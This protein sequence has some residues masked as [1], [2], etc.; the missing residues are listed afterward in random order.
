[1]NHDR[2]IK[3]CLR[4]LLSLFIYAFGAYL[5]IGAS[6]GVAPWDV[7]MLGISDL[8][9]ISYGTVCACTNLIALV[10][11]IRMGERIGLGTIIDAVC[12]GYFV[13][14]YRWLNPVQTPQ[15]LA[16]KIIEL[17]IGIIIIFFSGKVNI[18]IQFRVNTHHAEK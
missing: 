13:D 5:S 1:M 11:D 14:F 2:T 6:I 9:G 12:T 18:I 10:C 7:L 4:I 17:L 16:G 3:S 8:A 15:T